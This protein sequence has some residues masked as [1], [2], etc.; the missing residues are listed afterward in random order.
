MQASYTGTCTRT[1]CWARTWRCSRWRCV[2]AA[3]AILKLAWG[4]C[5][6]YMER[7]DL[8]PDAPHS[9]APQHQPIRDAWAHI[10]I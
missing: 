10:C 9:G 2:T 4:E 6:W 1:I 8:S 5:R 3:L 7:H